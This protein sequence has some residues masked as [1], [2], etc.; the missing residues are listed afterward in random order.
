LITHSLIQGSAEWKSYRNTK[1]NA[2]DAPA[3][4]GESLYKT[5]SQLLHEIFTG[6]TQEVDAG[7]QALFDRGHAIEDAKRSVAEAIIGEDLFPVVGSEGIYSASFDGIT[8]MEDTAWECKTLNDALRAALPIAG[9]DKNDADYLP[10]MY[11]I[12]MEQQCMVS[13][14]SRILFTASDGKDDDRHCWYVPD[15]ALR[16]E[17]VAGWAQFEKDLAEYAPPAV[18]VEAVGRTPESLPALRIEVTGMVTASNLAQYKEHALAVFGAINR[19]LKT[20]QDFAD[21]DKIVKWCGD[22]EDRLAA[23]KQHAL[24]QTESI[25]TL[26]RTIDE[27]G[28]EARRT[29]LELDKLVK[30]RKETIR[31]EIRQGGVTA[32]AK[33]ITSLNTRLGKSYMPAITADFA[34]VMKG[35]KTV[36]SLRDAVDTEL[37]R[38]KIEAN[39]VADR[40]QANLTTLRELA[41]DHAFLFADAAQ[42]VLK[43]A[44]D[45]TALVK[46]RIAEHRQKEEARLT[47]D[48]ERIAA[49]ERAK[50]E[51]Q[52]RAE[53]EAA[54][55]VEIER[56]RAEIAEDM[57][58]RAEAEKAD[59]ERVRLQ[60]AAD[61]ALADA[62]NPSADVI[63]LFEQPAEAPA[64]TTPPTLRLGQIS[65]RLGFTVTA[66]FLTTLGF[67]PAAT[68]KSAKLY[69]ESSFPEICAAL[70]NH[71]QKAQQRQAA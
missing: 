18:A 15:L 31:E 33:H 29:R 54:R 39:E 66:D 37:A 59:A 65:D 71:I 42:I 70:V 40:I 14:C 51:A 38:A 10:R 25:D 47:A 60:A 44:D 57:R 27:I 45:L 48:R 6:M 24:S 67:P 13:G 5:R 23:A 22:V 21:A 41:I 56:Q 43:P 35:K 11:R 1:R 34:G 9:P 19:D 3:M 17:I 16:A 2:S 32:M 50:A 63:E 28:A 58:K 55:R 49:E 68:D 7:T 52:V 30:A 12:Q 26:F 46:M 64:P 62:R 53:Q 36:A 69:H 4:M 20:D 61:Q 8:M